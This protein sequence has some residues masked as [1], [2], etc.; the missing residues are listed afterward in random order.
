M[1]QLITNRKQHTDFGFVPKSMT[2]DG[3]ARRK[4]YAVTGNQKVSDK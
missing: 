1:L 4:A 3:L 2:M